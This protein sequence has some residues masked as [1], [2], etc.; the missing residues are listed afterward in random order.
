MYAIIA[1][2]S[3]H[4]TLAGCYFEAHPLGPLQ[5]DLWPFVEEVINFSKSH[6]ST[7][8]VIHSMGGRA[9][10]AMVDVCY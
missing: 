5:P 8:S 2:L 7:L 4:I 10:A 3:I 9:A 1:T 6:G